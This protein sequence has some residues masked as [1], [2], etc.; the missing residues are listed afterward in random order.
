MITSDGGLT[1]GSVGDRAGARAFRMGYGSNSS[2]V[3]LP[4]AVA[5]AGSFEALLCMKVHLER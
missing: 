5:P 3:V 1:N 4:Q 2:Y